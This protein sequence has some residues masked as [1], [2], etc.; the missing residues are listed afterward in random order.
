MDRAAL[1]WQHG[2]VVGSRLPR[3]IVKKGKPHF[4]H[5]TWKTIIYNIY[6]DTYRTRRQ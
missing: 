6:L 1:N 5:M 4:C 2:C 3:V